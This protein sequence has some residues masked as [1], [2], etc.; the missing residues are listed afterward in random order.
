[1]T[2]HSESS[3]NK[4]NR[5]VWTNLAIAGLVA[6][7]IAI[8]IQWLSGD[9]AYPKMPPGPIFF[10]IVAGVV[11]AAA[12]WW[13]TPILASLISLLVTL[14]WFAR[15]TAEMQRLIHPASLSPFAAGIFAGTLLQIGALLVTD[16][17]GIVA[18]VQ[19]YRRLKIKKSGATM[20]CQIL[21]LLFVLIGAGMMFSPTVDKY[22]NAMHM[23][24]GACAFALATTT[25]A[26]VAK[27]YCFWSG[28]FYLALGIVGEAA[29]NGSM[30]G[31]FHIGAMVLRTSDHIFHMILGSALLA[32]GSFS[33]RRELGVSGAV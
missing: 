9:P 10:V 33:G 15:F 20:T 30:G 14:G 12:R 28:V 7:A 23:L 31:A 11:F 27:R 13:W 3:S 16:V 25:P 4:A 26:V 24:W 2:Q 1:M 32:V 8:W 18:T 22:H 5:T 29:G 17:A 21:G 6:S 19:N